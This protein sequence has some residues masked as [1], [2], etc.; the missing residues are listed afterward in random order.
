M[1]IRKHL[2]NL[3]LRTVERRRFQNAK[4][5]QRFRE[6]LAFQ[7]KW[8]FYGPKG[9]KITKG[10]LGTIPTLNVTAGEYDP[11][12]VILYFHG[13]GFVFGSPE[14]HGAMVAQLS[15]RLKARAILPRYRLAPE[16]VFPAAV[17][18]AMTAWKALIE[19][20]IDPQNI[21]LG[22][23]S[24]GG[25]LAFGLIA[26]LSAKGAAMPGAVF[27]FSPLADLTYSGGSITTNAKRE[28]LLPAHRTDELAEMFLAGQPANDPRCSPLF[29]T[30]ENAPPAWITVGD[31]EILLDDA[32]R[33]VEK[34]RGFG[35][36]VTYVECQDLPHVWPIMHNILPEARETLDDLAAW[37][38]RQQGWSNEN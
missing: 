1:S 7:A 9:T 14:T 24:A 21:V 32:R 30:F 22:G 11:L 34:M 15:A 38:R 4:T 8:F 17:D 10:T 26:Q 28:A 3:W 29:G 12:R 13:G 23:D 36:D 27:G 5:P 18:D 35:G 6:M 31:T 33:L 2:V 20:G 16:A 19:T 25:A 37:I